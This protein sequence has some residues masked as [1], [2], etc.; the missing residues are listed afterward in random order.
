MGK[1]YDP[2]STGPFGKAVD[3][4]GVDAEAPEA[5]D[6]PISL[7]IQ[8]TGRRKTREIHQI[9]RCRPIS[10]SEVLHSHERRPHRYRQLRFLL[11]VGVPEIDVATLQFDAPVV[12]SAVGDD[13]ETH[14]GPIS[15][16]DVPYSRGVSLD[17]ETRILP[18]HMTRQLVRQSRE[19]L[20]CRLS[21]QVNVFR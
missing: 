7:A 8:G 12:F 17:P 6:D 16:D 4:T 1:I 10:P 20:L 13:L 3:V 11:E 14:L 5:G 21:P 18:P 2:R 19:H 9:T 15:R